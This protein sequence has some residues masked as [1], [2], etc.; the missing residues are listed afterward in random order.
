MLNVEAVALRADGD[1]R[2]RWQEQGSS[3]TNLNAC[4]GKGKRASQ[5]QDGGGDDARP[6]TDT[7]RHNPRGWGRMCSRSGRGGRDGRANG[8]LYVGQ[9]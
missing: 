4:K 1:S 6:V 3:K 8:A 7:D 9:G 5:C 2:D